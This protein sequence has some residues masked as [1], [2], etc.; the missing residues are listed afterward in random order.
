MRKYLYEIILSVSMLIMWFCPFLFIYLGIPYMILESIFLILISIW[1]SFL[2]LSKEDTY[3]ALITILFVPFMFSHP[4]DAYTI[5]TS[6]YFAVGI[7]V[8]AIVGHF[9]R[10]KVKLKFHKIF[11]GF[12]LLFIALVI[13]GISTGESYYLTQLLVVSFSGLGLLLL[14]V[15]FTSTI[16]NITF[17]RISFLMIIFSA[18]IQIQGYI[19]LP[20]NANFNLTLLNGRNV[21]VGWGICNNID[22]IL[23]TTLPFSLY[24]IFNTKKLDKTFIFNLVFPLITLSSIIIFMSKGCVVICSIISIIIYSLLLIIFRKN[25]QTDK[26]KTTLLATSIYIVSFISILFLLNIFIPVFENFKSSFSSIN[27]GSLNGRLEIYQYTLRNLSPNWLF[28]K[29]IFAGFSYNVDVGNGTY[30]WCHST[31]IQVLYSCGI[32]GLIIMLFH[33][34]EKYYYLFKNCT[35][36]KVILIISFLASGIYGLFDVSYFFI[37]YMVLYIIITILSNDIYKLE[38]STLINQLKTC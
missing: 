26:F 18:F 36:E 28:G 7:V 33:L 5:P 22:L 25:K 3:Y 29:G 37:N 24:N 13:G 31:L 20:F 34:F 30:Q 15:F 23:A 32:F 16:K 1:V 2:L 6:L 35:L 21:N 17:K 27:V 14:I 12:V 19:A 38:N 10:F 8:L 9:F 11:N 4:F